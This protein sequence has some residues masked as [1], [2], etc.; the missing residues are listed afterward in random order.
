MQ[1]FEGKQLT[2][3]NAEHYKPIAPKVAT[4]IPQIR[5]DFTARFHNGAR[6][7]EAAGR[8]FDQPTHY[9]R[10][11]MEL[12]ELYDDDVLD[13][14]IGIAVDEGKMD[15]QSFRTILREYNSGQR[16]LESGPVEGGAEGNPDTEALTRNCSYYEEYVKGASH[17]G[18]SR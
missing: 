16:K 4:S 10:K 7:L 13:V 14:F 3:T 2:R 12:Q 18:N 17:A 11:I 9:A 1:A 6:Y 8:K 15:I 5:R